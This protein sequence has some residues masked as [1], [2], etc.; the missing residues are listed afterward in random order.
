MKPLSH[1]LIYG[2]WATLLLATDSRGSLDF[3]KLED[4]INVLID[5][6]PNGIYSNGTACEFYSQT[7]DEFVA[8]S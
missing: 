7:M 2:N 1:N 6:K 4:E 8:I 5:S 3:N